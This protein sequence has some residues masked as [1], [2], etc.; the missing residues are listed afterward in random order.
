MIWVR[1]YDWFSHLQ[2]LACTL[3]LLAAI[4]CASSPEQ[5]KK[6]DFFTSGSPDADRRAEQSVPKAKDTDKADTSKEAQEKAK[7]AALEKQTT[8]Y[9][10]LGGTNGVQR[11]VDDFI[12][13]ALEDPRV[14]WTRSGVRTKG[15]LRTKEAPEWQATPENINRLKLHFVQFISLA[16]GGPSKYDGKPMKPTHLNMQITKAEFDATIGDLKATLDHLNIANDVQK[17]LIAIFE[18]TRQQIVVDR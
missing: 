15:W 6:E 10:R 8:L 9:E 12:K 5:K 13:R 1:R 14:N 18:S 7:K 4:G 3:S 11:I 2:R 16:A 17:D